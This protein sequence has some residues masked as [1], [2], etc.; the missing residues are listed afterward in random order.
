MY[1]F[2]SSEIYVDV[3]CEVGISFDLFYLGNQL[4]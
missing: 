1:S 4:T 2:K 3:R